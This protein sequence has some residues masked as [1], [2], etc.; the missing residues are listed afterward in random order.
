M[1]PSLVRRPIPTTATTARPPRSPSS[2][3]IGADAGHLAIGTGTTETGITPGIVMKM[4]GPAMGTGAT[5]TE[6]TRGTTETGI[7]RGTTGTGITPG[8]TETGI[9][10]GTT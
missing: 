3:V 10:P 2:T 5:E 8:T 1:Q 9:T 4:V 6:I 7:T